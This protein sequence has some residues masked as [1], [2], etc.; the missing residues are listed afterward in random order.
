MGEAVKA[1]VELVDPPAP[2]PSSRRS[3]SRSAASSSRRTSARRSIDFTDELPRSDNGK[4]YKRLLREQYWAGHELDDHDDPDLT[5]RTVSGA[6]ERP[7]RGAAS[8]S[9]SVDPARKPPRSGSSA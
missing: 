7:D 1:V 2:D 4:L 8:H 5:S 6:T 9:R 3:C